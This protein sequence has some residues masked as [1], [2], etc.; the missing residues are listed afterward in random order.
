V[1]SI[2]RPQLARSFV[3]RCFVQ[4]VGSRGYRFIAP[5][6]SDDSGR[7]EIAVQRSA[8]ATRVYEWPPGGAER[9][10]S[11]SR[12]PDIPVAPSPVRAVTQ[13]WNRVAVALILIAAG[14]IGYGI[15]RWR[16][17]ITRPPDFENLR[18]TKLTSSGRAE[19]VA[20]AT[21][22]VDGRVLDQVKYEPLERR[23][24]LWISI[25]AG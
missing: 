1:A 10:P 5:V 21:I 15:H 4:T 25:T 17:H 12:S 7:T 9:L 14:A 19:D 13:K 2:R 8:S 16:S 23:G 24:A 3:T 18:M 20:Q 22:M 11:G 6:T